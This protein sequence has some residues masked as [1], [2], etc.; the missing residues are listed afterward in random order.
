ML[1]M[2]ILSGSQMGR[3]FEKELAKSKLEEHW[4]A[5]VMYM[6]TY[7]Y[8]NFIQMVLILICIK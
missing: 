8:I 1:K 4:G 5:F 3:K 2:V 6:I 7:I